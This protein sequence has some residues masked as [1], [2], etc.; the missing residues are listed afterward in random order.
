MQGGMFTCH[1]AARITPRRTGKSGV[2]AQ[3]LPVPE[4][5]E[6]LE[7]VRFPPDTK[8]SG[9]GR[10]MRTRRADECLLEIL[11]KQRESREQTEE[12]STS[13]QSVHTCCRAHQRANGLEKDTTPPAALLP[14]QQTGATLVVCPELRVV[15]PELRCASLRSPTGHGAG[16]KQDVGTDIQKG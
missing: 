15:C 13:L 4:P 10:Q 9:K 1:R 16:G 5:S 7:E 2:V 12:K 11:E 14:P 3:T 6:A 8:R